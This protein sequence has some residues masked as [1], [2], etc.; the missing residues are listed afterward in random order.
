MC[1]ILFEIRAFRL[2]SITGKITLYF[3]SVYWQSHVACYSNLLPF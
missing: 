3:V 1:Q 2:F